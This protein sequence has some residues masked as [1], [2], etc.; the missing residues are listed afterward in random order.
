MEIQGRALLRDFSRKHSNV[1]KPLKRW[2]V[3]T[4]EA[5]WQ[6]PAEVKATFPSV[7]FVKTTAVFNI[8][9]NNFRLLSH[10]VYERLMV[11]IYNILV[12]E[13]YDKLKI[14]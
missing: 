12:H 7:S 2:V 3:L 5:Q 8:G 14:E 6:T 1:L 4:E 13:D 9:G 11:I 10:I